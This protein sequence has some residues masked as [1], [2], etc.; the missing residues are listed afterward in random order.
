MKRILLLLLLA[1]TVPAQAA[2]LNRGNGGEPDSLD[3]HFAGSAG[4][5][6]IIGDMLVG[7]TT[8][9]AAARPIPGMAE[10]WTVSKDGLTWTFALRKA[11]WSD[12][13]P[14]TADDFAFAFHRLLNPRTASRNAA[15]LWV[16]K[17]ARAVSQGRLPVTQLGVAAP[18]PDTLVLRLEHPAPY[19]PE[20]LTHQSADPLPRHVLEAKGAGWTRPGTYVANG[21]YVLKEWAPSDHITLVKNPRFYDA[22]HVRIDTVNYIPTIDS[23]AALRR[24]R[25][26][27]L[28]MQTPVPVAQ[29]GWMRAN[30]KD[31]L[32][33][34]PSLALG[35]VAFNLTYSPL[36]DGRVRRAMALAYNREAVV[37]QV[38]KLGETPAYSYVPPGVANYPGG[39][40]LDFKAKPYPARLT[41]AQGLM[42]AAGYGPGHRLRLTY[43]TS[44][45]PDSRRLAALFQAMMKPVFIDIDIQAMDLQVE[46]SNLHQ[47]Q[48]Q[49]GAA[50]WY[51]D[52]NDASNFLDLLQS[53]AGNNYAGY[54]NARFD[55]ALDAAQAEPDLKA[56]G[57]KLLAAERLA[58][59]DLPWLVTRFNAQTELVQ[60]YVK[61]YVPNLRDYNRTRWLWLQK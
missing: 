32:Y 25:A 16:L 49:L 8:L 21:P 54:R 5:A 61:G 2:T 52:F 44:T 27:E 28:D 58:L 56:R 7:L 3:P 51:A 37:N 24:F 33:I 47:H 40:A 46:L 10:R 6:N 60:P 34:L 13:Q 30:L 17:N 14:V 36:K 20:L 9:D 38:L 42:R 1:C 43:M 4:E 18:R 22:A 48:F 50:S 45:N 59:A 12:G 57:R 53:G 23:E 26:G 31:A 15:N 39:A 19:L 35:Y 41:E 55:A 29:L 11:Q